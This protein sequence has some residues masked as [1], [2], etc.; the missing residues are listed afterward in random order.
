MI[1][2]EIHD[3]FSKR[4]IFNDWENLYFK[5][6]LLIF[7]TWLHKSILKVVKFTPSFLTADVVSTE[8]MSRIAKSSFLR[9]NWNK[10]LRISILPIY[11]Y[12][13]IKQVLLFLHHHT[14]CYQRISPKHAYHLFTIFSNVE[15]VQIELYFWNKKKKKKYL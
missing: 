11:I 8:R 13:Y 9:M 10:E 4:T 3:D 2:L 6:N 12:I 15:S 14:F 7:I 1:I 5:K